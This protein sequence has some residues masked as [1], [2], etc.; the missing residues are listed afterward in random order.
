V[1]APSDDQIKLAVVS[2]TSHR[3]QSEQLAASLQLPLVELAACG[4]TESLYD[5]A[6]IYSELGL[7]LQRCGPKAPG[8][9]RIDFAGGVSQFRRRHGGGELIVKALGGDKQQ[10]PSVIDATAGLGRDSFVLACWGY[11]VTALERSPIVASL[12]DDGLQ[13]ALLSEDAQLREVITRLEF[14]HADASDYLPSLSLDERPDVIY[15]DPMFPPSKKSALVKKQMQAFHQ[16]VGADHDSDQLLVIA[17]ETAKYRVVVKRAKKSA[18][19]ADRKPN[20]SLEGKAIRFDI[21]AL[22][23]YKFLKKLGVEI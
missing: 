20:F 14:K 23:S 10:R 3:Q 17:L 6:L 4:H 19:L 8:P 7:A 12:L 15:I 22:K 1:T 18:F 5:Y 21:Y 13:R 2:N 11:S 9:V 16:V